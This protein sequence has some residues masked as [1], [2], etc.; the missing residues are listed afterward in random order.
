MKLARALVC[1]AVIAAACGVQQSDAPSFEDILKIDVHAHIFEDIPGFT[2]MM[3]ENN[4]HFINICVRAQDF[5]YIQRMEGIAE[6]LSQKYSDFYHFASTFDLSGRDDPQY[7]ADVARWLDKSFEAGAVMTKIWKEVGMEIKNRD[8]EFI[9]PDDP[10]FDPVYAHLAKVG[11]PLIAHLA[12]P[13][14]AWRPLDPNGVHYGYYS[15]NPEWHFYGKEGVPGY[16]QIIEA[17]DNILEKHPDLIFIGAHLGSMS[18]DVDEVAKRLDVYPNFY[19]ETGG[20]TKGLSRQ[21]PEKVRQFFL[22][23]KDRLMYGTDIGRVP[24]KHDPI[25][26]ERIEAY[27]QSVVERYKLDYEYY[28][29][30]GMIEY[31]GKTVQCLGLPADVLEA[32]F[33]Q[34]AQRILLK[35]K[36]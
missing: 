17:R 35:K 27:L 3:K 4:L 25:P 9:M 24:G 20:R 12:E 28:A 5:E 18:H 10:I 32:Y 13:I 29:G 7:G 15:N 16:E 21:S 36:L 6:Q 22:K 26:P 14:A 1:I 8:G 33:N 23:Y 34:N 31:R 2:D 19:A 30:S 11:K